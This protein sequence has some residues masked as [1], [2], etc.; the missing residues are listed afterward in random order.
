MSD[1]VEVEDVLTLYLKRDESRS[2]FASGF[3]YGCCI[4][5]PVL[6]ILSAAT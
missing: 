3:F 4:A 6:L 2:D 5:C 1:R